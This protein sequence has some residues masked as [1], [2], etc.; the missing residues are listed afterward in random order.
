[1]SYASVLFT[2]RKTASSWNPYK[3]VR[4]T[5]W[6]KYC[7]KQV[8]AVSDAMGVSMLNKSFLKSVV[9]VAGLMSVHANAS[10]IT[11]GSFEQAP[12][13]TSITFGG[14][15]PAH[16]FGDL[17]GLAQNFS[18]AVFSGLPGWNHIAG[19]GPGVEVHHN[20][21]L[22]STGGTINNNAADGEHYLVQ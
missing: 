4:Y 5:R 8:N 21:T 9:L 14:E 10:L 22:S 18:W 2:S 19:Y 20:G 13:G 17:A 11:N 3:S 16:S 6:H 12:A 15:Q 7:Q 1:M